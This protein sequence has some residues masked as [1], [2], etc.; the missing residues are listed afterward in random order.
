MEDSVRMESR[1]ESGN[2]S[3][4]E[5]LL[6]PVQCSRKVS[7]IHMAEDD[8]GRKVIYS[9]QR[10]RGAADEDMSDF[11]V[12]FYNIIYQELIKGSLLNRDGS[13]SDPEFA[14]DTMNSFNTIANRFPAAGK[15]RRSRTSESEWPEALKTYYRSYHCLANFWLLPFE[16]GRSIKGEYNKAKKSR[17]YM[18]RFLEM[19]RN[20][21]ALSRSDRPYFRAFTG[22]EDFMNRHFLKE[23]YADSEGRIK[24]YSNLDCFYFIQEAENRMKSRAKAIAESKYAGPLQDY[25]ADL[26]LIAAEA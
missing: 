11:S 3:V 7:C 25:F 2:R 10:Y 12:G 23:A 9:G 4:Y 14:G 19:L 8:E 26:R 1:I 17:D 16:T 21:N 13:L 18:D 24:R 22:W 6:T 15:N 20:E 5:L